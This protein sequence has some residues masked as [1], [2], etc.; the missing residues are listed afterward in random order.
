[1]ATIAAAW[2]LPAIAGF[3]GG[4]A[5][6]HAEVLR[7]LEG[8]AVT[9]VTRECAESAD[10]RECPRACAEAVH[11]FVSERCYAHIS[12]PQVTRP[13]GST[14]SLLTLQGTW[15]ALYPYGGLEL[16]EV[17][18]D[19]TSKAARSSDGTRLVAVKLTGNAFVKSGRTTWE[20]SEDSCA[21]Q[22]SEFAGA[23][24]PRWGPCSLIVEDADHFVIRLPDPSGGIPD[25][26]PFVRAERPLL[27]DWQVARS[28]T[29][30]LGA[31]LEACGARSMLHDA[32]R[33]LDHG[34]RAIAIDQLLLVLPFAVAAS[35]RAAQR[36]RLRHRRL[37][38]CA[39]PLFVA[40]VVHRLHAIGAWEDVRWAI[41]EFVRG[42]GGLR[43]GGLGF[44]R[45]GGRAHRPAGGG[46]G[47]GLLD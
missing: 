33:N 22:Y 38:V 41:W 23:F 4:D 8:P 15:L 27:L 40:I 42:G 21:V 14:S 32:L 13:R 44:G 30:G 1:M 20:A 43:L 31:A 26:L 35:W 28:P 5:C 47:G 3:W 36:W 10:A 9:R 12:R 17:R 11:A 7:L 18:V 46:G 39:I 25:D 19:S 2:L 6:T 16:V 29:H 45:Q 34:R 37:L 24:T